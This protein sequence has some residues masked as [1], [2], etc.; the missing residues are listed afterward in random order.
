MNERGFRAQTQRKR[1][2]DHLHCCFCD[3][4]ICPW[5][6]Y[7]HVI[8]RLKIARSWL[9]VLQQVTTLF[10]D[11]T[12]VI[13]TLRVK[14][15][16]SCWA[17]TV[18]GWTEIPTLSSSYIFFSPFPVSSQCPSFLMGSPLLFPAVFVSCLETRA[19]VQF[20]RSFFLFT[21]VIWEVRRLQG[22]QIDVED[23]C[24]GN[25]NNIIHFGVWLMYSYIPWFPLHLCLTALKLHKLVYLH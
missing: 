9:T 1:D 14:K 15:N 25:L 10:Q 8:K 13:L 5:R 11:R 19:A 2:T 4:V 7:W 17:L 21:G 23:R 22:Q 24:W 18:R 12:T 20:E 16:N 6:W 3:S